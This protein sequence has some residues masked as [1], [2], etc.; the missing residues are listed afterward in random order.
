[1]IGITFSPGIIYDE[2]DVG[3]CPAGLARA[4]V[5]IS[6]L[7]T[8]L[9]TRAFVAPEILSVLGENADNREIGCW[10]PMSALNSFN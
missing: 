5:F 7:S 10:A 2:F 9:T 3:V 6:D 8:C 1:M 4:L